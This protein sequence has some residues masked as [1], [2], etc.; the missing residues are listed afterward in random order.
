M[1]YWPASA[2]PSSPSGAAG[3]PS[4][5]KS[6]HLDASRFPGLAGNREQGERLRDWSPGVV[7]GM[8]QTPDYARA[9]LGTYPGVSPDIVNARLAG[10][11]ERQRRVL[12]RE[13][14]PPSACYIIDHPA[15]YRLSGHRR[16][17]PG[18]C[19]TLP[20]LPRCRTSRSRCSRPSPIPPPRAV[21]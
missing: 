17:W 18:R 7:T 16:S 14:D 19:G 10:R 11:M 13:D 21:S 1:K 15:L 20:R 2:T 5:T 4:T 12:L 6:P 3:S 8:L 9:L